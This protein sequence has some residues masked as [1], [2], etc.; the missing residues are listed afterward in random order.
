MLALRAPVTGAPAFVASRKAGGNVRARPQVRGP[1]RNRISSR[2]DLCAPQPDP[3][4]FAW[5][6][7]RIHGYR[8]R[9][10]FAEA[11]GY[12]LCGGS[13]SAAAAAA[14]ASRLPT[15]TLPPPSWQRHTLA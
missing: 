15:T 6:L 2:A 1:P 5:R 10:T 12:A 9:W 3:S 11:A 7:G 14:A 4:F 8:T 13:Y